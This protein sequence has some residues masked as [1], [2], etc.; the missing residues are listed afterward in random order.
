MRRLLSILAASALTLGLAGPAMA[1]PGASDDH[2][3]HYYLSLGDSLAAGY[4]PTGDP[5]DMHRTDTGYTDQLLAMAQGSFSKLRQVK[6]G[7]PGETTT[8]FTQGGI[9]AYEYGSQ[10]AEAV[11]FL[12]AH[13]KFVAFVTIDLG[14]DDFPCQTSV[15]CVAP[16]A[17][18][19]A[20]NLPG[21]LAALRAAAGPDVRIVGGTIYDPFLPYWLQGTQ[22]G[23]DLAMASVF[24]A[25]VPINDLEESIYAQF[26][27]P[28]ADV[29]GAFFTTDF[30][31]MVD[32]PFYP[33]PVPR[34]VATICAWTWVCGPDYPG[35][36][37]ANDTGYHVMA[38][39]Y[40]AKLGF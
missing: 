2:A 14:W 4:Q 16:G 18:Q 34:N 39:A 13:Q 33:V 12:H 10:L 22:A 25:I 27:M 15:D 26:D 37:H 8:T 11:A 23:R 29:E 3:V 36:F 20:Q 35:D 1:A 38:L 40:R 28:V 19:I 30:T 6:L 31:T 9:C 7:C 32:V 21:I 5:A 24:Q 17:A